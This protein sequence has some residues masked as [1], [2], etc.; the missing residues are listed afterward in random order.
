MQ[1]TAMI[2]SQYTTLVADIFITL[3]SVVLKHSISDENHQFLNSNILQT[4][5]AITFFSDT[6]K[7]RQ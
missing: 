4:E 7:Q 6:E 2:F 1:L 3:D 5:N